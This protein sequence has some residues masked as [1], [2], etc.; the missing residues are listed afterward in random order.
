L[1]C[2]LDCPAGT[3]GL[4]HQIHVDGVLAD[5]EAAVLVKRLDIKATALQQVKKSW[6]ITGLESGGESNV[7]VCRAD[8]PGGTALSLEQIECMYPSTHKDNVT[9]VRF[10]RAKEVREDR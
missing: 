6:S 10:Y 9:K 3:W 8:Y 2:N 4:S 5:L 1:T 7:N